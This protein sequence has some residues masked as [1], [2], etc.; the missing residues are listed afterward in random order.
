MMTCHQI[1]LVKGKILK[2]KHCQHLDQDQNVCL[3]MI[4]MMK[5]KVIS[6]NRQGNWFHPQNHC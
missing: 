2:K 6:R 1:D 4:Q 3:M 5:F